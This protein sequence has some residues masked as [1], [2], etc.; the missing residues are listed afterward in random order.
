MQACWENDLCA[1]KEVERGRSKAAGCD[2]LPAA[3]KIEFEEVTSRPTRPTQE[4]DEGENIPEESRPAMGEPPAPQIF[5]QKANI[6]GTQTPLFL[7]LP[8]L[9][10]N[11]EAF[12]DAREDNASMHLGLTAPPPQARQLVPARPLEASLEE[13]DGGEVDKNISYLSTQNLVPAHPTSAP[14]AED[15]SHCN[16]KSPLGSNSSMATCLWM[17]M[18]LSGFLVDYHH[19][20]SSDRVVDHVGSLAKLV[21]T[22]PAGVPA[23]VPESLLIMVGS[24]GGVIWRRSSPAPTSALMLSS[25]CS[26]Q[27]SWMQD[28]SFQ[29][30]TENLVPSSGWYAVLGTLWNV[31]KCL[32]LYGVCCADFLWETPLLHCLLFKFSDRCCRLWPVAS[33]LSGLDV[34]EGGGRALQACLLASSLAWWR[35]SPHGSPP[36][37]RSSPTSL[38]LPYLSYLTSEMLHLWYHGVSN[39]KPNLMF[40]QFNRKYLRR[41]LIREDHQARS[42][43][44]RV[45]QELERREQRGDEEAPPPLVDPRSHS[46]PLLPEEMDSI[47]RILSRNLQNF[48]NKQ[49]PAYSRH[50]LHQD[51]T[52]D[53]TRRPLHRHQSLGYTYNTITHWSQRETEFDG[54]YRVRTGLSRSHTVCSISPRPTLQD[55][56]VP[57]ASAQAGPVDPKSSAAKEDQVSPQHQVPVGRAPKKQLSFVLENEKQQ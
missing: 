45:Y 35:P 20:G 24:A 57:A 36:E 37:L 33:R 19:A 47:R 8:L 42:S 56:S 4:M 9:S 50:T 15:S 6:A 13:G 39:S 38:F 41:F 5:K 10:Q 32:S 34:A 44:L 27:L 31:L 30:V 12:F 16:Q 48:N 46:R 17:P 23:V 25:F 2:G 55:S 29:G 3:N 52:M 1:I 49:T 43:I 26:H 40:E 28:T 53:K 11:Y 18:A 14:C 51:A 21:S 54:S 7:N 22:G